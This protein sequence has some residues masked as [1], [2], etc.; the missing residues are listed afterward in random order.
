LIYQDKY[1]EA[2]NYLEKAMCIYEKYYPSGHVDVVLSLINIAHIKSAQGKYDESLEIVSNLNNIGH[3]QLCGKR[4]FVEALHFHQE[5]LNMLETYHPS[6]YSHIA[7][8]LKYIGNVFNE[9]GKTNEALEQYYRALKLLEDYYL[10]DHVQMIS[11]LTNIRHALKNLGKNEEALLFYQRSLTIVQNN[12][13]SEILK[14]S[15]K[16]SS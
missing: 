7:T 2:Y 13:Q 3:I 5:A 14:R 16:R 6:Y 15:S 9:Q 11:T 12:Y 10:S 1:D 8:T 4:D